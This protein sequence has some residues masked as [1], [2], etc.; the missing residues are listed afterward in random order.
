MTSVRRRLIAGF[1]ANTYGRVIATIVQIIS[2]PV[3]LTH[4]G[5]SLYG[6]WILLNAIPSYFQMSD[7][8]FGTVAGNEMTMLVAADRQQEAIEV[9]QSVWVLITGISLLF[10]ALLLGVIWFLPVERWFHL[11]VLSINDARYIVILLSLS[12]LLSMQE[13]LF[14]AAFRCVGKYAFGTLIKSTIML[15]SFFAIMIVVLMRQSAGVAAFV[16]MLVN[17]SGTFLMW[18]LLRRSIP[19]IRFGTKHASY[20][21]VKRLASPALSFICFPLGTALSLQGTLMVIGHLLGPIAVV[22]FNTARTI[23]RS[24]YQVMQLINNSVWPEMSVAFGRDDISLARRLHRRSC[25]LSTAL[26]AITILF[27]ALF[28]DR[29]WRTW[30]YG[31]L[32][33]DAILLDTL[34]IQMLVASLWFT[35]AVVPNSVNKHQGVA[36]MILGSTLLSL[37]LTAILIRIPGLQL[38]GAAIS[39][40]IGDGLMSLYV[41]KRSLML[42]NDTLPDFLRSMLKIPSLKS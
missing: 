34:L 11:H 13:A 29:I 14:Q 4:W 24:G 19:W 38:R 3:F 5:T 12:V 23:S 20:A 30:T 37:V 27:A 6:E 41:L 26:C 2:V 28:G 21:T 25:Q 7:I 32:Q 8:G 10:V 40:V 42:V 36:K 9:F 17:W 22:T 15:A 16:V 33:T 31:K 1:G 35:S 18:I 39:L